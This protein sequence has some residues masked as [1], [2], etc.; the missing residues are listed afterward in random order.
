[1]PKQSF[2]I[3]DFSGGLNSNTQDSMKIK[4]NEFSLALNTRLDESGTISIG[5]E[6]GYYLKDLPHD[7]SNFQVGYGLFA[8]SF[9]TSS[10]VIDAQFESGFEEG[11]VAGYSSTTLTL[12]TLPTFQ[13]VANHSTNDF[14][15]NMTIVITSGNGV[16]QSR[17]IVDYTG[18]NKEATITEVFSS[19]GDLTL[20]SSGSKYKIYNC[21]GDNTKFGNDDGTNLDLDYID[22]GGT[23]FPYDDI[24]AHDEN[25]PNSYFLRTKSD[26]LSD[27]ASDNLGF[28]TFNPSKSASWANTDALGTESTTIGNT[29]LQSGLYI[30]CHF[31]VKLNINTMVM[32]QMQIVHHKEEKEFLLFKYIQIV[33]QM[34]QIQVYIYFKEKT[35]YLFNLALK[36]HMIMQIT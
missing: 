30:Q 9:D 10:S 24:D 15:N 26:T 25:Y 6:L 23:T 8:T 18:S 7:N 22:K 34:E 3:N 13:S 11:T 28:V 32:G 4:D 16:G 12:A 29:T 17:R 36:G 2:Y 35:E 1:M 14:Y 20:P 5:G 27:G 19:A 33:L 21:A 31:G